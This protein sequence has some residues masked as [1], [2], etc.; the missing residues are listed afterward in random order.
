M[1]AL[2]IENET[3]NV[4]CTTAQ[5]VGPVSSAE[6]FRSQAELAEVAATWPAAR[7]VA[8]WNSLPGVTPVKRFQNRRTGVTRIW[9]ALQKPGGSGQLQAASRG[10]SDA[11]AAAPEPEAFAS[12]PE[13][14]SEGHIRLPG[15]DPTAPAGRRRKPRKRTDV[16]D[17]SPAG[18]KTAIVLEMLK[19]DGGVTLNEIRT[20][21][22]WQAHSVRGF[23][24]GTIGKKMGLKIDSIKIANQERVYSIKT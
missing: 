19:R 14:L 3:N 13:S 22:G 18:S 12:S 8:I 10:G 9:R 11:C 17:S 21:T 23:L 6:H 2:M 24:S 1:K 16:A 15:M 5:D 20:A 7:L 4:I